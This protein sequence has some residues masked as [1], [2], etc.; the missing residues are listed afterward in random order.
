MVVCCSG[1]DCSRLLAR[2]G[3]LAGGK[4]DVQPGL[5]PRQKGSQSKALPV[6]VDRCGWAGGLWIGV[7]RV[8]GSRTAP[9]SNR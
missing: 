9:D 6:R 1:V 8:V 4:M 3:S 7:L 5:A 2:L